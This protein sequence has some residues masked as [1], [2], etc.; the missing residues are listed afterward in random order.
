MSVA[1]CCVQGFEWDGTP[2]GTIGKLANNDTSITGNNPDVAV[3]VIHD[4]LSWNFHNLRLLA[5][6]YARETNATV[7]LPDFFGGESL[8][9]GP[10]L[11]NRFHELDI[12]SLGVRSPRASMRSRA[13]ASLIRCS[14][15]F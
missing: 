6:H 13:A 10:I 8:A 15:S 14:S 11:A 5:D 12:A 3:L 2:T 7:Y 9:A 4:L 1:P